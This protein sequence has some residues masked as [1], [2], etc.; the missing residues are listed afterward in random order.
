VAVDYRPEQSRLY[1][2]LIGATLSLAEAQGR[3]VD[4]LF[5]SSGS[6]K[7]AEKVTPDDSVTETP[8]TKL[9]DPT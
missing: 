9:G 4:K 5:P 3:Y 6:V 1:S 7:D 8:Q 2:A